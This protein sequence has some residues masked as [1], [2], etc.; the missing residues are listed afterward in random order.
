MLC[1]QWLTLRVTLSLTALCEE[2]HDCAEAAA[3]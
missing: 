3:A 1:L 2:G